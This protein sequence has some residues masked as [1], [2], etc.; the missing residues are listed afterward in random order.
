MVSAQL[1]KEVQ[2]RM[3]GTVT[4]IDNDLDHADAFKLIAEIKKRLQ[5]RDSLSI[6]GINME[7]PAPKFQPSE[8]VM[9]L[10]M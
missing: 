4:A 3:K 10:P 8:V 6:M 7:A 2:N 1:P 5:L 9:K